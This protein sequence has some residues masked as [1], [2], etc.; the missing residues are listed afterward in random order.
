MTDVAI[1]STLIYRS[2][3]TISI[4]V[5]VYKAT[6]TARS[7]TKTKSSIDFCSATKAT[8]TW[9]TSPIVMHISCPN[10]PPLLMT[11]DCDTLWCLRLFHPYNSPIYTHLENPSVPS[12]SLPPIHQLPMKLSS[13]GNGYSTLVDK[14]HQGSA[15][16][17]SK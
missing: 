13:R 6:T 12:S 3:S 1:R 7:T 14:N 11:F 8:A 2:I 4:L 16:T 10:P 17:H 5:C 15:I 9:L